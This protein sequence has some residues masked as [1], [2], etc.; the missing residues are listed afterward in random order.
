VTEPGDTPVTRP[1]TSYRAGSHAHAGSGFGPFGDSFFRAVL[2][3][4]VA[5]VDMADVADGTW[6]ST[7]QELLEQAAPPPQEVSAQLDADGPVVAGSQGQLRPN[8]LLA[9]EEKLRDEVNRRRHRVRD[10][11]PYWGSRLPGA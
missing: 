5:V 11:Q 10:A 8:P 9:V 4:L 6:V 3:I 1:P 7:E 2:P